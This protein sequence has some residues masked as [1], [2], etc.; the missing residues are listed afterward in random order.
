MAV[1]VRVVVAHHAHLSAVD[2]GDRAA[3]EGAGWMDVDVAMDALDSLQA[4]QYV[5]DRLYPLRLQYE[6]AELIPSATGVTVVDS[7]TG[8]DGFLVEE[9]GMVN[10]LHRM[11]TWDEWNGLSRSTTS[12]ESSTC[13][14]RNWETSSSAVTKKDA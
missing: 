8:H 9:V 11:R 4:R 6:L 1:D 2:L 13:S 5:S 14:A 3:V 7:L 10:Q 12:E